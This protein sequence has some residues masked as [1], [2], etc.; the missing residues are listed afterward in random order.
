MRPDDGEIF[1]DGML[2]YPGTRTERRQA[3]GKIQMLFQGSAL[4]DSMTVAQNVAFHMVEHGRIKPSE[5]NSF[6]RK[7]LEMVDL[8][9]AGPLNPLRVIR[10][11]AQTRRSGSISG[12]LSQD[13]AL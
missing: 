10:R 2:L 3:L 6:S 11:H 7:Y 4:F 9:N 1:I 13:H 5:A 8:A 12:G